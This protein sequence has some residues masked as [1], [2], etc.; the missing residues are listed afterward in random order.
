MDFLADMGVSL[1]VAEWLR[2]QGHDVLHLREAGLQRLSDTAIF[3]KA[4]RESRIVLTFDLDFAEI[5][6]LSANSTVSTVIFRLHNPRTPQVI[7][8][9]QRVLA[10][11]SEALERGAVI[12]VEQNRHRVRM[13]PIGDTGDR[14]A[15]Y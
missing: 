4:T 15:E 9:L 12:I 11:S 6:A 2:N 14:P 7:E 13:L 1:R 5:L 3:Q 10:V 8:R